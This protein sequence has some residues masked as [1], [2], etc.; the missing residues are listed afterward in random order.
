MHLSDI[1]EGFNELAVASKH[2]SMTY[3]PSRGT[4]L[5]LMI[6]FYQVVSS[7]TIRAGVPRP[8]YG[9]QEGGWMHSPLVR[10]KRSSAWPIGRV[11]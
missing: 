10:G 5:I 8:D 7:L 2:P 3:D 11:H 1:Y 9:L 4:S 6:A